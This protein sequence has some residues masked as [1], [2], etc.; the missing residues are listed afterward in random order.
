MTT[1]R[2]RRQP[3]G[4]TTAGGLYFLPLGGCGEI[5]MNLYLYGVDGQWLAVDFG[6]SFGDETTPGVDVIMPDPK[7]LEDLGDNLLGIVLTHGHEDHLGAIQYLWPRLRCPV[8]ATPFTAAYLRL[9]LADTPFASEIPVNEMPSG[10]ALSLGPFDLQL[11]PVTHSIPDAQMLILSTPYGRVVHSGD[12]KLDPDPQLGQPTD[13]DTLRAAGQDGVL[14]FVCDSTNVL[15]PG[16]SGSEAEV[17]AGLEDVIAAARHR[18]AVTCFSTHVARIRS[19]AW[20]AHKAGRHCALV[21]RSLW[22]VHEA[23][24]LSGYLD[25]PEPFLTDADAAWL[26]KDRVVLV[27]TGSQGEARSALS[28]IAGGDHPNVVLEAGDTL[29]YSS[30][31]IPGNEAA[32]ERI[33][34]LLVGRG[35]RLVTSDDAMVHVSGH[36]ARDEIETVYQWLRPQ[37]AIPMHGDQ[38]RLQAQADL[39][40]SLQVPEVVVPT[41]GSLIRLAP[42]RPQVVDHV[43]A[44]RLGLDGHRLVAI[45][46]DVVRDRVRLLHNGA[47]V[48]TIVVNGDG[49][50]VGDPSV[51]LMGLADAETA[52]DLTDLVAD[53]VRDAVDDLPRARRR[54]DESIRETA[55]IAARRA[56][57]SVTGKRPMT[58]IHL[59]RV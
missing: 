57:R 5:G 41:D 1:P 28:R 24:R 52:D 35:V 58:T 20:A 10:G 49:R 45:G 17:L 7:F 22:R 56:L 40:R 39:A 29:V 32:I 59:V 2:R 15:E 42:G 44:E 43:P 26:P 18:V 54:D 4:P 47:V 9:K 25:V 51:A 50:V 21:G 55:R 16:S 19:I 8:Y 33:Q 36:P 23:A 46:G 27:C 13:V 6:V 48:A 53:A 12:W 11:V 30:R 34:S 37:V 14:A 31:E 38:R 3:D